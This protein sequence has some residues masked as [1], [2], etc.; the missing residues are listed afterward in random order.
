M[1]YTST[2]ASCPTPP[3]RTAQACPTP[4]TRTLPDPPLGHAGTTTTPRRT[5]PAG[6]A[7]AVP[8][9]QARIGD[10]TQDCPG[11]PQRG[12]GLIGTSAGLL[13]FWLM[14]FAA[15]QILFNLYATSMVTSSA[16]DAA[17]SV[18]SYASA[19]D[20]CAA[21]P[22]AEAAF[23]DSLGDYAD[24]SDVSL[25]W[26]CSDPESVRLRVE[27]DHPTLLPRQMTGLRRLAHL[28]RT[29][30]VRLEESR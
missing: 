1:P 24:I 16:Y 4:P 28:D 22:A 18:A 29:I 5:R 26:T 27:A 9:G 15:V 11:D 8:A 12:A 3:T 14:M 10:A 21:V 7:A 25:S 30:T 20:R 19:Q 13:V 17:R 23:A 2:A 6:A